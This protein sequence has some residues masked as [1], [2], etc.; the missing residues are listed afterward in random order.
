MKRLLLPS[1]PELG[2]LD[3][4]PPISATI[5]IVSSDGNTRVA[6][7]SINE[8]NGFLHLGAYG[9]EFSS[10][11]IKVTLKQEPVKE[12]V[13]PVR[14]SAKRTITCLSGKTTKKITALKP[15]C[16]KGYKLKK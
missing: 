7:T 13:A 8:K 5:S 3:L 4:L 16:P 11:T 2:C 14:N 6:T 12:V 1:Q 10:P 9:F 15:V